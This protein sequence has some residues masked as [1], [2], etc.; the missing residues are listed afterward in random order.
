M[1]PNNPD[2]KEF[3]VYVWWNDDKEEIFYVGKGTKNRYKDKCER[4]K[5]FT[6]IIK[7]HNCHPE[8]IIS[9]LT[10]KEALEY[11]R[12][13]ELLLR[14]NNVPLVNLTDCGGQPPTA[15]GKD[16]PNYG[17]YW[18][19]EQK[20]AASKKM[21]A[22]GCHVGLKNGRCVKVKVEETGEVFNSIKE[23]AEKFFN[24]NPAVV[25]SSIHRYGKYKG[26]RIVK[27]VE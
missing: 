3:Y 8:I 14:K 25:H 12:R 15:S 23:L 7:K 19:E 5:W 10:S 6:N 16:N 1:Q 21:K 22:S 11:E 18:T 17:H 4:N 20:K 27:C 24:A 26:Y 2:A 9:G 13:I